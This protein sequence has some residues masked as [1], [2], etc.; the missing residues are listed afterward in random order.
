[1]ICGCPA[2]CVTTNEKTHREFHALV[3]QQI[4]IGYGHELTA[5][6]VQAVR[7]LASLVPS[8]PDASGA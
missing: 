5:K 2:S 4:G 7:G 1:M 6:T 3:E 8:Q